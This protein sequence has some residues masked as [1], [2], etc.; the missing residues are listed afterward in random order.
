[1]HI[2]VITDCGVYLLLT[3]LLELR[4]ENVLSSKIEARV[5][6]ENRVELSLSLS[7]SLSHSP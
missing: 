2:Y 7:L 6:L 5:I 1:M 4:Y 3:M